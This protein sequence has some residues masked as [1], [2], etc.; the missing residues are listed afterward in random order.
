M[1]VSESEPRFVW[2]QNNWSLCGTRKLMKL[3]RLRGSRCPTRDSPK[4]RAP[5]GPNLHLI[6]PHLPSTQHWVWHKHLL[7]TPT[8]VSVCK[9]F[10]IQK[11]KESNL[12]NTESPQ[13]TFYHIFFSSFFKETKYSRWSWKI[14]CPILFSSVHFFLVIRPYCKEHP[15]IQGKQN[16]WV[17][18][19]PNYHPPGCCQVAHPKGSMGL[20]FFFL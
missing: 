10:K 9:S 7:P 6:Q 4:L 11:N 13:C 15:Y 18:G 19:C 2:L 12:I 5:A 20:L 16:G 14:F 1:T 3:L 17:D 8:P